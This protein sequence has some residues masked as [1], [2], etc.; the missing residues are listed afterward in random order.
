MLAEFRATTISRCGICTPPGRGWIFGPSRPFRS[1]AFARGIRGSA[2]CETPGSGAS[3]PVRCGSWTAG[4]ESAL[5][6]APFCVG[7]VMHQFDGLEI[8]PVIAGHQNTIVHNC[9][10]NRV[11]PQCG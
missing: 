7:S 2:G 3:R 4:A 8:D 5:R 1:A 6:R 10:F 11:A 9:E